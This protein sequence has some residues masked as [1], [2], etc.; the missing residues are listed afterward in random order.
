MR[1]KDGWVTESRLWNGVAYLHATMLAAT[2][3]YFLFRI[4][5]Q[6]ADSLLNILALD[7]PFGDI[8]RDAMS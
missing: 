8:L 5:I 4:P 6:V 7:R 1:S 3:G 2:L